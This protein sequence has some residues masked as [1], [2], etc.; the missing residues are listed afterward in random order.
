MVEMF[1]CELIPNNVIFEE[2]FYKLIEQY[3]DK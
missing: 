2:E 3:Y 1:A